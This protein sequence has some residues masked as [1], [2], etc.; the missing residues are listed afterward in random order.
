MV[1]GFP[2]YLDPSRL[3]INIKHPAQANAEANYAS[4]FH[5]RLVEWINDF[6]RELDAEHEV[7]V[8]LV[9]FGQAVTFHIDGLGYA[10]PSLIVFYGVSED[11]DPVELIQHVSQISVLLT[12]MP[13]RDPNRPKGRIGFHEEGGEEGSA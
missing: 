11:G 1:S 8:R 10:N 6:D 13:R 3:P 12:K 5:S 9:T 7:G 4:E 2:S